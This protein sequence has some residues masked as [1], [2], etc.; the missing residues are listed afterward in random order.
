MALQD[1]D[2]AYMNK[3]EL[4]VKVEALQDEINFL[5]AIYEEV[6]D[7]NGVVLYLFLALKQVY[8]NAVCLF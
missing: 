1:V 4:E 8:F 3:I 7:R 2:T 6:G 5:R